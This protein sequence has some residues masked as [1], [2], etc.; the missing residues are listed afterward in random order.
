MK[1]ILKRLRGAIGNAVIWGAAW[2]GIT[3][4]LLS[5]LYVAGD[6]PLMSWE[7]VLR[8]A[9][10]MGATGFLAGGAFSAFL[11]FAYRDRSLLDINIGWFALGGAVV[12][13]VGGA[14]IANG[15]LLGAIFGGVTAAGTIKLAKRA[16]RR[17]SDSA[18]EELSAEQDQVIALLGEEAT[19]DQ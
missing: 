19:Q 11:G 17:L 16:S 1:T 4:A 8:G 15:A 13:G 10:S 6:S 7:L 9:S 5:I 14:V 2:F 12:A 3:L 18:L